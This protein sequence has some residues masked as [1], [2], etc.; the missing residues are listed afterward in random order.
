MEFCTFALVMTIFDTHTHIYLPEFDEDR[1]AVVQRAIRQG[2]ERM[3]LPNVDGETI[4]WMHQLEARFPENCFAMMGL[5][6]CSVKPE[7]YLEELNV[8]KSW[9]DKRHYVAVGEIGLDLYWDQ[10][11]RDIQIE[12]L[13]MQCAW[14]LEKKLPV[15]IHSRESTQ[16]S[17]EVIAPFAKQGLKG[18]F[19][20][21]SGN[22]AEAKQLVDIGF[23]LGIGGVLTYKK[24]N[25]AQEIK[26]VPLTSIILETDAPYL[27]PVPYRGKRNEPSY[28]REVLVYLAEARSMPLKAIAEATTENAKNLFKHL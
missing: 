19:H 23:L 12:A 20:C 24:S 28:I 15:V 17:I 8:V 3:Y 9:L 21:F 14:A 26:D 22:A 27:S 18:V 10:S 7:S 11:T 5:H 1:D 13:Q 4:D 25:L 2:V 16:L 6:P